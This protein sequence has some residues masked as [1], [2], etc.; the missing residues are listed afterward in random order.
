MSIVVAE[1]WSSL[2]TANAEGAVVEHSTASGLTERRRRASVRTWSPPETD[3]EG[4]SFGYS[5]RLPSAAVN[6]FNRE[7][8]GKATSN[9]PVNY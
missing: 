7:K 2:A 1:L 3:A 9:R 5:P 8:H 4:Y 6:D